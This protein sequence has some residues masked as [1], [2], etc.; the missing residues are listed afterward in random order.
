MWSNKKHLSLYAWQHVTIWIL[1]VN[2]ITNSSYKCSYNH[3]FHV[4]YM[5][6]M[7]N[8]WSS[9]VVIEKL[10]QIVS[11][12]MTHNCLMKFVQCDYKHFEF[13]V[14]I[15]TIPIYGFKNYPSWLPCPPWLMKMSILIKSSRLKWHMYS[16]TNEL[17]YNDLFDYLSNWKSS[18]VQQKIDYLGQNGQWV[19]IKWNI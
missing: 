5:E 4:G 10:E 18:E 9:M 3:R 16:L 12:T 13:L 19:P 1:V 6:S 2:A 14:F 11:L 15:I 8:L 17:D 7:M